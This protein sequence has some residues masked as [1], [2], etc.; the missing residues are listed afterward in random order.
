VRKLI[1]VCVP[2]VDI[3][4]RV[5]TKY[6]FRAYHFAVCAKR[7]ST[8]QVLHP[9][10]VPAVTDSSL[11][12]V[13]TE[14]AMDVVKIYLYRHLL[15]NVETQ[16][17]AIEKQCR[18]TAPHISGVRV[19]AL[20]ARL[21]AIDD[22]SLPSVPQKAIARDLGMGEG[23]VGK[24]LKRLRGK[25][26][27]GEPC[28]ELVS[29]GFGRENIYRITKYGRQELENWILAHNTHTSFLDL[30]KNIPPDLKNVAR[31]LDALRKEAWQELRSVE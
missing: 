11:P 26:V 22:L 19:A 17:R 1:K 29:D 20:L 13:S 2:R 8:A 27:T 9:V 31:T 6:C 18:R 21:W 16:R 30:I 5:D 25:G 4:H 15:R 28:V 23:D 3:D 7:T 14:V 12:A 24:L 10:E